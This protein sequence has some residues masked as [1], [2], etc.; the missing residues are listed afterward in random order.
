MPSACRSRVWSRRWRTYTRGSA[1]SRPD[2]DFIIDIG[3]Q[4][5]KCFKIRN[6]RD[7]LHHR[8]TRHA[9]PAAARLSRRS[10]AAMG[11]CHRGLLQAGSVRQ[12]PGRT[13]ARRCTVFMNSSVKQAQKDGASIDDIS[14]GLSV[15]VVK[16]ALYKVIRANSPG[17]SAVS[18]SLCRAARSSMTRFCAPLKRKSAPRSCAQRSPG[19]D[20][21]IRRGAATPRTTAATPPRS[22]DTD[23][24]G[25]GFEHTR[26][27]HGGLRRLCENHCRLTINELRRRRAASGLGQPAASVRLGIGKA[28]D[29]PNLPSRGKRERLAKLK[30]HG[31]PSG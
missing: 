10:P 17:R 12:A 9:R 20:G 25:A 5:I 3:G 2:V 27:L 21:R 18:T 11:Y 26:A 4:D 23:V 13:S 29:T 6:R 31:E 7:R 22:S 8:S 1:I 14:A 19:A 28:D 16:N 15:T 30:S 24:A